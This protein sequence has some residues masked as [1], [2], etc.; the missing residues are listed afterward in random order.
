MAGKAVERCA[1]NE[2]YYWEGQLQN[3]RPHENVGY[4]F[5]K[6]EKKMSLEVPR[7]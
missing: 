2:T 6:Q 5:K 7:R 3:W 4:T 1:K